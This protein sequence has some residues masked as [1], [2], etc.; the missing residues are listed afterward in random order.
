MHMLTPCELALQPWEGLAP[1]AAPACEII[2]N[3][4]P[5]GVRVAGATL[6]AAGQWLGF[7]LLLTT[8]DTPFEEVLHVHLFN[9]ELQQIDSA[10]I[11][12]P[13]TTG[14]FAVLPSP[15]E[16]TMCFR[17]IG[18]TDWS[19]Q[20]LPEPGFRMPLVSEPAGVMRPLGFLRR[21]IVRG[22]PQPAR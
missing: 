13:Y 9:A 17:F 10:S 18:H 12:G 2:R 16:D 1:G 21:F 14:S 7:L 22:H 19:V 4:A 11:G 3:A 8:D 20:I 15:A 6:E 5:T